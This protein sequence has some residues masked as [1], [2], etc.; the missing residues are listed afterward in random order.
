MAAYQCL[1]KLVS[2]LKDKKGYRKR[3]RVEVGGCSRRE[4]RRGGD[5]GLPVGKGYQW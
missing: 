1:L 4:W 3:E 2:N 5:E